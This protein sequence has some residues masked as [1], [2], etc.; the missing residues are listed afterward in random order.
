M[1]KV[2]IE[3]GQN[4]V[5]AYVAF[6]FKTVNTFIKYGTVIV[7]KAQKINFSFG[8]NVFK[9]KGKNSQYLSYFFQH[10]K[11]TTYKAYYTACSEKECSYAIF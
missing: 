2:E 5:L 8:F 4:L 3:K 10:L 6:S 1:Y 11:L 7:I 9:I